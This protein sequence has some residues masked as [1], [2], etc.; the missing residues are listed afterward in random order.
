VD[1]VDHPL[2]PPD[3]VPPVSAERLVDGREDVDHE[4]EPRRYPST[5]GG[6]F[7]LLMLA[8]SAV[9]LGIVVWGEWR[10]GIRWAGGA[11][12]FGSLVRLVLPRRDAG[13]L[14]VR[15]K[16]LDA[17]MLS[18]VGAAFFFLAATIPNQPG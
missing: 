16:L 6:A 1:E 3:D 10:T 14:A 12:V 7:Y 5:V 4:E 17:L 2:A 13:M 9:G 18:A 8:V 15:S 11:L